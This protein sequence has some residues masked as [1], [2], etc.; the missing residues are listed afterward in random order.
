MGD[1]SC[2]ILWDARA[3]SGPAVKVI[4]LLFNFLCT[5][6]YHTGS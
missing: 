1:D 6:L 4:I 3:G 2:L 5:V